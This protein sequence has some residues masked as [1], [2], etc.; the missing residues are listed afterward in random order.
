MNIRKE[1]LKASKYTEIPMGKAR[2]FIGIV[3][4]YGVDR[5]EPLTSDNASISFV[6]DIRC[7]YNGHRNAKIFVCIIKEKYVPNFEKYT[8]EQLYNKLK[9]VS[10]WMNEK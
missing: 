10:F 5:I 6:Y 1:T 4:D 3:D 7:R 8:P 9:K 2:T